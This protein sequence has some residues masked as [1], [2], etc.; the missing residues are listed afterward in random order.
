MTARGVVIVA[1]ALAGCRAIPLNDDPM[2]P[3]AEANVSLRKVWSVA[4]STPLVKT[5]LLEF[6]PAETAAPAVDPDTE[7][8]IA[9]TRDGKVHC[10]SPIDGHEEWVLN[11]YGR[12]F[13][14]ATVVDGIAYIPG[15]DGVL[16]AVR[17]VGGEKLWE[18]KAAEELVTTPTVIAG[19]VL[20]ASQ[21]E[22]VFAVDQVTGKWVWQYRRDPPTGFTIRGTAT[23]VAANGQVF[24][25]FADGYVVA[26]GLEDGVARWEKKLTT[27][28]G[29]QF[30]DV[31][32][33]VAV[34]G[35]H[36]FAASYKDGLSSLDAKTGDLEWT[37]TRAGL[38]SLA[39][40][41]GVLFA[42]GDGSLTAFDSRK[43][44]L[45]WS[46]NIS[47]SNSKGHLNNS[48]R[49][50]TFAR[51]YVVM[52]TATALAFVDP[53]SGRVSA[54][55][56]PG[57]GVTASATRFV[58]PRFGPRLFVI[59]N[60]GTVFALDLSGQGQSP[61]ARPKQESVWGPRVISG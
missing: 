37:S 8:V 33:T 26:L 32:T 47:D 16:Y 19:K 55:W 46:V 13:A 56:N 21:S 27:S 2:S 18:Y 48:G 34:E 53:A 59:S 57:R 31:D 6:Q 7:R 49:P 20:V 30:L 11:T 39:I 35:N 38:N 40:R 61:V 36:V 44:G 42:G 25:G 51:G 29:T 12:P 4:W 24:M 58:S 14:G 28:G 41:A 1:V 23:P 9:S 10:L 5:G 3:R 17:V 15:G 54:M 22:T 45:L 52:P 50:M 43:G 60:L